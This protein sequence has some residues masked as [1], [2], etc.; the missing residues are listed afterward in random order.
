MWQP[1]NQSRRVINKSREKIKSEPGIK[2]SSLEAGMDLIL[3]SNRLV[4]SLCLDN[5]T[6]NMRDGLCYSRSKLYDLR[7]ERRHYP[8]IV[9][10]L[11]SQ[12]YVHF[13]L[14]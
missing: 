8:Q 1:I 9:I 4:A 10:C 11:N 6:W 2:Y 13:L 7:L 12:F 14:A 5:G 3:G